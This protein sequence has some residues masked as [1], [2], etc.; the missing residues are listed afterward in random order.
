MVAF[1]PLT[2]GSGNVLGKIARYR[3]D[4]DVQ[5]IDYGFDQMAIST[6]GRDNQNL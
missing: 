4:L 5:L 3:H 2:V 1:S 6:A